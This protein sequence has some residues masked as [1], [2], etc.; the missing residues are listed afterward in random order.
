[1]QAPPGQ[2]VD[3]DN[4]IRATLAAMTT[5]TRFMSRAFLTVACVSAVSSASAAR[6]PGG[7]LVI[8]RAPNFGWN[9]VLHVQI[10][11]RDAANIVQARR[12]DRP[13]AAG[14]HVISVEP[15]P[16][17]YS[18]QRTSIQ[19]NVKPGQTYVF[20]AVWQSDIVYLRP[21]QLTASQLAQLPY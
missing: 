10:D 18:G 20:T 21:T 14:T 8:L 9:L 1:L 7:R 4:I 11:G 15:V 5:L 17:S 12:Y 13:I 19:L 16:Y 3:I 6:P 2:V